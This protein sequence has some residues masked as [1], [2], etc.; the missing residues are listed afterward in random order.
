MWGDSFE[1]VR[2]SFLDSVFEGEERRL[3]RVFGASV[4]VYGFVECV[5]CR[6]KVHW[7]MPPIFDLVQRSSGD[8]ELLAYVISTLLSLASFIHSQILPV[9]FALVLC[10]VIDLFW[11]ITADSIQQ[12]AL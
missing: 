8:P 4:Y 9:C 3:A 5:S 6:E 7:V 11:A 1:C 10:S 12:S 2:L